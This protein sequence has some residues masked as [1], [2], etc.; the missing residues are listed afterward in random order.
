MVE[1]HDHGF[2]LQSPTVPLTTLLQPILPPHIRHSSLLLN[3]MVAMS[4]VKR[5]VGSSVTAYTKKS[6][7]E[8]D[9]MQT[10]C[11]K[12]KFFTL[13]GRSVINLAN[14]GSD[15]SLIQQTHGTCPTM[16]FFCGYECKASHNVSGTLSSS[17]CT[18]RELSWRFQTKIELG[19]IVQLPHLF[20]LTQELE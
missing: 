20:S 4:S 2:W 18:K 12:S 16:Y 9:V 11:L 14:A 10:S 15:I 6:L 7:P 17:C 5:T 3:T 13:F 19:G 1:E 8:L